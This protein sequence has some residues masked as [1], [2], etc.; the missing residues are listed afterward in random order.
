MATFSKHHLSGS[1]GGIPI[2]IT[3]SD[4]A[5]AQVVHTTG[6]SA[7]NIDEVWIYANNT[8]T[9]A[10]ELTVGFGD[11]SDPDASIHLTLEPRSG[12]TLVISGLTLSGDGAAGRS[13]YAFSANGGGAI[14][15]SGYVNRIS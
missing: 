1:T 7:S 5:S 15:I 2:Q 4:N 9:S 14:N 8:S 11:T 13:I 12:L 6:I 3:A 10:E